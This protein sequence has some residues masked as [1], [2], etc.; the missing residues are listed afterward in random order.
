MSL[1]Q[2]VPKSQLLTRSFLQINGENI[3]MTRAVGYNIF[4]TPCCRTTYSRPNYRSINFSAWEYWTD[5]HRDGSLMP[6]DHGLRQCQCGNYYLLIE[7]SHIATVESTDTP[8]TVRVPPNNL[9]DAIAQARTPEIEV[10]A[11]LDYWQHLNHAYRD[12]YRVHRDAEEQ[13][14]KAAWNAANPD[15]RSWW[16]KFRK[17]LAPKYVRPADSPFTYPHFELTSV[18]LDNLQSLLRLHDSDAINL[19]CEILAELYRELGQFAQA[20]QALEKLDEKDQSE[21]SRLILMLIQKKETAP[22]RYRI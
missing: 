7:L 13:A 9:P 19:N 21:T 6:N 8:S 18:Q 20:A 16:Q 22:M 11:R 1:F 4:I 14:T 2:V 15:T 5:G 10:A 17:N 12:R 3:H